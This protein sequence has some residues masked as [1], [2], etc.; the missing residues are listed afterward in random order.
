[1]Y[2]V[3]LI[4]LIIKQITIMANPTMIKSRD[5]SASF[6]VKRSGMKRSGMERSGF[7]AYSLRLILKKEIVKRIGL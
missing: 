2:P 1:M 3:S 6:I 7:I 4:Q 5:S